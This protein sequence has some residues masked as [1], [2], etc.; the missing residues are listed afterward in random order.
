MSTHQNVQ[1]KTS[2]RSTQRAHHAPSSIGALADATIASLDALESSL[3]L[4]F[5]VNPNDAK[6][7]RAL[8][9][10]SPA[11]MALAAEVVAEDPQRFVDFDATA[12]GGV[13]D[14]L[15]AMARVLARVEAFESHVVKSRQNHRYGAAL[16]TLALYATLK[17]L[18]RIA[19]NEAL[20]EK[21]NALAAELNKKPRPKQTVEEKQ[22]KKIARSRAKRYAKALAKAAANAP[23]TPAK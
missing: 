22:A 10:V 2:R 6:E 15:D 16:Q 17:G 19:G 23:P 20:R 3:A 9:R 18:G 1:T 14:Y 12:L 11:A 8:S 21:A 13:N 4:D 5:V 7:M